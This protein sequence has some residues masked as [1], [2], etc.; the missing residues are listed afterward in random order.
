MCIPEEDENPPQIEVC[1]LPLL[2]NLSAL[3]FW[4]RFSCS[5]NTFSPACFKYYGSTLGNHIQ[6]HCV[7]LF[8]GFPSGIS[9]IN[10]LS[11]FP[12]TRCIICSSVWVSA[13][14]KLSSLCGLWSGGPTG[15]MRFAKSTFCTLQYC[16]VVNTSCLPSLLLWINEKDVIIFK[17]VSHSLAHLLW[18]LLYQYHWMNDRFYGNMLKWDKSKLSSTPRTPPPPNPNP[19]TPKYTLG[20][21]D[22][23]FNKYVEILN[24]NLPDI[25]L[26]CWDVYAWNIKMGLFLVNISRCY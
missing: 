16:I 25:K 6:T 15:F 7:Y 9:V 5:L 19:P 1:L 21:G 3:I 4:G 10:G 13:L 8:F 24:P 12:M 22:S 18:R 2:P 14:P 23:Q 11:G 17:T 26:K 20:W